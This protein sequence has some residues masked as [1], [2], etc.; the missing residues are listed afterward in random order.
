MKIYVP[1]LNREK[2]GVSALPNAF[3]ATHRVE[4]QFSG[5]FSRTVTWRTSESR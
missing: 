2:I 5:A 3:Q 4:P 1:L